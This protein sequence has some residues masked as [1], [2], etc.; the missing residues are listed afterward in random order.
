MSYFTFM[1]CTREM[2]TGF[3][4]HEPKAVYDSYLEYKSSP[5]YVPLSPKLA[6]E[7]ERRDPGHE[8]KKE[9]IQG[10]VA[11]YAKN[12]DHELMSVY[13][14]SVRVDHHGV[15]DPDNP[16]EYC[17]GE[18]NRTNEEVLMRHFTLPFL[19][20]IEGSIEKYLSMYLRPASAPRCTPAGRAKRRFQ[21]T[22]MTPSSTWRNLC[23]VPWT[24]RSQIKATATSL[25]FTLRPANRS[26]TT[27]S[28][29]NRFATR[30]SSL[31]NDKC[32]PSR[33]RRWTMSPKA[34]KEGESLWQS[35]SG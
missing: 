9:K 35:Y 17:I 15:P 3:F 28:Q 22:R 30:W 2:P 6:T 12:S 21:W 5:D 34:C 27:S 7:L 20:T 10:K 4:G 1:A 33:A 25:R 29:S 18:Y 26:S 32:A 19:Y 14:F 13:P 16:G 23:A 11:V 31:W 24:F 8:R